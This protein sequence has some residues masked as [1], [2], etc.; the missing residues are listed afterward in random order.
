MLLLL[1]VRSECD[2]IC[3]KKVAKCKQSS[4]LQ[5]CY[6]RKT[7]F[8]YLSNKDHFGKQNTKN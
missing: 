1:E 8:M 6:R 5:T 2:I 4:I 7:G 3:K